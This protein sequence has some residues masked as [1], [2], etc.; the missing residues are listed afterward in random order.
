MS[1]SEAARR[2]EVGRPALSNLLNGKATLSRTM[3]R[4]L[5]RTFGADAA[6]LLRMQADADE[7]SEQT[8][9]TRINASGYLNINASDIENWAD[10]R[11]ISSRSVLPVLVRR[12]IH[13]TTDGVTELDFH[14]NEEAERKG[15]DGEVDTDIASDKV[16][17]GRSGWELSCSKDLPRKPTSDISSREREIEKSER[18]MTS[19]VFVSGRRWPGKEGWAKTRRA[20]GAWKDVRA[21]DADDLAQWLEY[22]PAT[23]IWFA[24]QIDRPVDGV[25]SLSRCWE[26][27]SHACEP[28]LPASLFK[29]FEEQYRTTL[30]GWLKDNQDRPLILTADS[31]AEGL[32]FLSVALPDQEADC[33]MVVSTPDALQRTSAAVL[34]DVI[35]IDSPEL[36]P[37]AG[38]LFKSH[39][40]VI[41]RPKTSI[42]T[43]A[44]I[45]LDQIEHEP[46]C[47]ALSDMGFGH[48]DVSSLSAQSARSAT[49]LRRMF[50]KAPELKR[51]SWA[52]KD[53][54]ASRKLLPIL[55]AGAWSKS[56]KS[57]CEIVA[58]LAHKPYDEV[59]RDIAELAAI[60]D[61]P[62]W[63]IGAYRG[64]ICRKD[65]LFA[66]HEAILDTDIEEFL[67]W[68]QLI[69]SEDDP[70][71]D[72]E[73]D[74]R[75]SAA[76]YNKKRDISGALYDSIG[77]MLV[78]LSVYGEQLFRER[79]INVASKVSRV[80]SELMENK[81]TRELMSLSPALQHLAE[82]AP[83]TFLDCIEADLSSPEPQ[84][85][86]MLRSVEP[87]SM[88]SPDRTNLLWAL[89]LLA[90]DEEFYFRV[91]RILAK[92]SLTP[93]TDNWSNKPE[94]SL[95]SLIS[96]WHP[97]TTVEIERRI[98]ALRI[99]V[100]EFPAVG[101]R[102]CLSQV[103]A[104]HG[105]ATPNSR[106]TYRS[107]GLHGSR[108]VTNVEFW[109]V[110]DTCWDLLFRAPAYTAE[111]IGDLLQEIDSEGTPKEYRVKLVSLLGKWGE[112]ASEKDRASVVQSLRRAGFSPDRAPSHNESKFGIELRKIAK[113]LQP[114]DIV[115][116]RQWLFAE[117]YIPQSR[118]ELFDD[119][120]DPKKREEWISNC[121]DV[122]ALKIYKAAGIDGIFKLI[123]S[124][125]ASFVV[126]RHLANGIIDEKIPTVV[127]ELLQQRT[128]ED[129]LKVRSAISGLLLKH[130]DGGVTQLVT[131]IIEALPV[132]GNERDEFILEIL[133]ACPF[134]ASTWDLVEKSYP[135]QTTQYWSKAIPIPWRL[136]A[137]EYEQMI[138]RLL[139]V[140]RPRA[141]FA[142]I[143]HSVKDVEPKTVANL[144]SALIE[145]SD[146]EPGTY[147]IDGYAI[148]S[149][150][151]YIHERKAVP[152]D[153][154]AR[155]E[156]L[157]VDALRHSK[158]GIPNFEQ[159]VAK[160]PGSFVELVVLRYRREDGGEDPEE[161]RLPEGADL[162]AVIHKVYNVLEMISRTP[163]SADDG[164]I[165]VD[166][167][168]GWVKEARRMLVGL[169]REGTGNRRIGQLLGKCPS[170]SDG[171]W[172]H[173]AVRVAL[174]RIGNEDILNGMA[175]AV[176]N[177]R[178]VVWRGP[179]GDQERALATKYNTWSKAVALQFPVAA[180]LLRNIASYYTAD[181]K[182][183]M[184][185]SVV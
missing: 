30:H 121:R 41:V 63:A 2:L 80:V 117:H 93:I 60:P 147:P 64:A 94:N 181:A 133:L 85:L 185:R 161:F 137:Q 169:S 20:S 174:E 158:H 76:I 88:D 159:R 29:G 122:A 40:V 113:R 124:G 34:R 143:Y 25:K 9:R 96:C 180:K 162:K 43:S 99:I 75:W 145:E 128:L 134:E 155:F 103:G 131:A 119:Q 126:G 48:E 141:A 92:L 184:S 18:A 118:T 114:S 182:R 86:T 62:V 168:I 10:A 37:L 12:L 140:N 164:T 46:F 72:L 104:M 136:T 39:R 70:A 7:Q 116:R 112:T 153:A 79:S 123:E 100:Q 17:A 171:V 71:L 59:E 6:E 101:W 179:G 167:L 173:E 111:M 170:G 176:Y 35:V 19:F 183:I 152:T 38:P 42:E 106:P 77:E 68:A 14:G 28:E 175:L 53:P 151:A 108:Q 138:D 15:W 26:E 97:E 36:E 163:G 172:P 178:G 50:A 139:K 90:W 74:Q 125:N 148:D 44:G 66:A 130:G 105:M 156:Y 67:D 89:E 54:S 144:L 150:L 110:V 157:F 8:A 22:S 102:L 55:F 84:V 87:G 4:K 154:L 1:V 56:N 142:A 120:F 166:A 149:A 82:A 115:E 47:Q 49:I 3:A 31:T 109:K 24:E 91:V 57:D 45:A 33:A 95:E 165:D 61:A 21:Y 83:A 98:Q 69:L 16:P 127:W 177:S 52:G 78:L 135:D 146:E 23:Q 5:E 11:Q 129:A 81:T 65:A 27:W 132:T 58:E 13:T 51:P 32:A 160:N 73:P 107:I